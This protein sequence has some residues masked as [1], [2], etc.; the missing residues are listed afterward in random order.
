[1]G[2]VAGAAIGLLFGLMLEQLALGV[3]IGAA[4]GLIGGATL[5]AVSR[6]PS[7]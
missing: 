4:I 6:P 1:M 3:V 7:G 5:H 2:L